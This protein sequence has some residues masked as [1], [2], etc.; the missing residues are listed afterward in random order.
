MDTPTSELAF[1]PYVDGAWYDGDGPLNEV[2]DP[3]TEQVVALGQDGDAQSTGAAVG[4]ARRAFDQG[5][6][7][8]MAPK[9][10]QKHLVRFYDAL[11]HRRQ[12]IAE[13][14]VDETGALPA[15]A[16]QFHVGI[17]MHHLAWAVEQ[18]GR[19]RVRPVSPVVGH[20]GL[21][22]GMVVHEPC[23]VVAALT[24]FN[25]PFFISLAKVG[26]ALAAGCTTVLKPSP[27]TP[28][29]CYAL[30]RAAEE[31]DLPPG[32]LNIVSGD[33]EV[34]TA[35]TSDPRVD[36]VTFTGS[37]TV[38]ARVAAQAA[39]NLARVLLELG[40]KSALVVRADADLEAAVTYAVRSIVTQAGQGCALTTRHLVHR[41]LHDEFVTQVAAVLARIRVGPPREAGVG[42]GP[43]IRESQRARVEELVSAGVAEGGTV[44][45]GGRRPE[46][47][48]RGFFYE[49]TMVTGL[50][51]SARLAREEVF[52]PVSV[53][54]P[55]DTDEE[56]VAIANDSPFGL[57]GQVFS[58]D[59]GAAYAICLGV[60][61]GHI[62]INGGPGGMHPELPFG[63]YKRSG[64]GREY[65]E[66]GLLD[67][68][69]AKGIGFHAG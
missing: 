25:F 24:P 64:L 52:G 1:R 26:Q 54:L 22:S 28:L 18:S 16:L 23:G 27:L 11:D 21:G 38:G 61:T 13:T 45:A 55:F 59:T 33:V 51:N 31:A 30:A 19:E 2:L 35:L 14:V 6:W 17:A 29:Q 60:R 34:G 47:L 63:G 66:E 39:P 4:A 49:P 15:A 41:S 40:G 44:V 68:M 10:R 56:A 57:G 58:K 32:V 62:G 48:D 46:G 8:R 65:G 67:F 3:A 9:T 7:G 50:T 12:E 36:V 43:L 20:A 53:V 42:M 69:E 37:D 5:P